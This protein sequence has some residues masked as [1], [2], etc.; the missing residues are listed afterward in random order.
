MG[1]SRQTSDAL[2]ESSCATPT[3]ASR[4]HVVGLKASTRIRTSSAHTDGVT[5]TVSA[6]R[7]LVRSICAFWERGD[8]GSAEWADAEIEYVLVDGP[9]PGR[10]T[11]LAA[12]GAAFRGVLNAYAEYHVAAEEFRELDHERVLVLHRYS[13]RG[14]TSGLEIGQIGSKGADLFHISDGK[15]TRLV[16]YWECHRA[17]AELGLASDGSPH[18]CRFRAGGQSRRAGGTRQR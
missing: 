5:Q 7:D 18:S 14:K 13:G 3:K 17:L 12:M 6:N 16:L 2:Q 9:S 11:G 4:N 1:H 15:V 10:W 8:F